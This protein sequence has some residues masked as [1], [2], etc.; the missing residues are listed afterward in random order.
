MNEQNHADDHEKYESDEYQRIYGKEK[1]SESI[2][3]E[4]LYSNS[5]VI[6]INEENINSLDKNNSRDDSPYYCSNSSSTFD[7]S[8]IM[9]GN[10]FS[11]ISTLQT[12]LFDSIVQSSDLQVKNKNLFDPSNVVESANE[13]DPINKTIIFE[14]IK[15]TSEK[16]EDEQSL[17]KINKDFY[18]NNDDRKD[19]ETRGTSIENTVLEKEK[20]T[21]NISNYNNEIPSTQNFRNE[22]KGIILNMINHKPISDD[23]Y[24]KR[25]EQSH[26]TKRESYIDNNGNL[27]RILNAPANDDRQNIE[28]NTKMMETSLIKKFGLYKANVPGDGNCAFTSIMAHVNELDGVNY[29][30]WDRSLLTFRK[31]FSNEYMKIQCD[32]DIYEYLDFESR[33]LCIMLETKDNPYHYWYNKTIRNSYILEDK[34]QGYIAE[35]FWLDSE[36]L[37]PYLSFMLK[38]SIVV[39]QALESKKQPGKLKKKRNVWICKV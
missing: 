39:F 18:E 2:Q 29:N 21:K 6:D 28:I 36:N 5:E 25:L 30:V 15:N 35:E 14:S 20:T 17:L 8:R 37:F 33:R 4:N 10:R 19:N 7:E 9:S 11:N 16:T 38:K 3:N 13:L 12:L 23:V 34:N 27:I 24:Q 31:W 26:F 32:P 22:S 1:N